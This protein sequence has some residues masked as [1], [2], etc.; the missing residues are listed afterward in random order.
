LNILWDFRLFSFGYGSRGAGVYTA[1]MA[2]AIGKEKLDGR[3]LIWGEKSRVPARFHSLP[4][5]WIEYIPRSWKSDCVVIPILIAKYRIDIFHYWIALGPIF[6][7]GL[8]LIHPCRTCM[9]VHD[10]GVEFWDKAPICVSTRKTLYWKIQKLL[11]PHADVIACN[12]QATKADIERLFKGISAKATVAYPPIRNFGEVGKVERKKHFIALDGEP[13]KNTKGVL[14]A[15]EKFQQKNPD[16]SLII[17]G[18]HDAETGPDQTET[19]AFVNTGM[20]SASRPDPS[21]PKAGQPGVSFESMERYPEHLE[22]AAG[23][24]VCSFHEGLG[25]PALE[26]M[27]RGC[28]LVLSD[29]AAFRE[30]CGDAAVFVDPSDI[31]SIARGMEACAGSVQEWSKRSAQGAHH[32]REMCG[33]AGEKWLGIYR[34]L[35][36]NG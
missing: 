32:Y 5:Q 31:E 21:A 29:I 11:F 27:E 17:L 1:A 30:T 36:R 19:A 2:D 16:Y 15:F 6:R 24:V 33:N 20:I 25:L 18:R 14:D 34:D 22:N 23:M 3:L 35:M 8:G 12:S 13:H 28:P 7:M 26:A 10:A 4:A 9:T